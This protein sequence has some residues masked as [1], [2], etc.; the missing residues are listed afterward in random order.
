MGFELLVLLSVAAVLPL[1]SWLLKERREVRCREVQLDFLNGVE[2]A[3]SIPPASCH[4]SEI[5]DPQAIMSVQLSKSIAKRGGS[6]KQSAETLAELLYEGLQ[7]NLRG[8]AILVR[9]VHS[10]RITIA[11]CKG[12]PVHRIKESLFV[13]FGRLADVWTT[14]SSNGTCAYGLQAFRCRH[15]DFGSPP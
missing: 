2:N 13:A 7:P 3:S 9:D 10:Q 4:C 12:L 1:L 6:Q 8:L 5:Q 11:A 14:V 15:L